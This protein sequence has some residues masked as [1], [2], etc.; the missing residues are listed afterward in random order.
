MEL[1]YYPCN[2]LGVPLKTLWGLQLVHNTVVCMV[3]RFCQAAALVAAG[4]SLG[5]I[6]GAAFNL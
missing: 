6:Q 4:L 2:N 5:T 3:V 1:K